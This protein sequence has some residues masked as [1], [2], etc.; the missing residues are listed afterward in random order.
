MTTIEKIGKSCRMAALPMLLCLQLPSKINFISLARG[1][2]TSTSISIHP[3][4]AVLGVGRK[5][6]RVAALPML[7]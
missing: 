3:L 4:M 6:C 2:E 7:P 5:S 1:L